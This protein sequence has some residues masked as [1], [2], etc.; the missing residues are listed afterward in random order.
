MLLSM[1]LGIKVKKAFILTKNMANKRLS[2]CRAELPSVCRPC[3]DHCLFF[4]STECCTHLNKD[5]TGDDGVTSLGVV[6]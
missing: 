4:E 3:S 1:M 6:S 5:E 2:S